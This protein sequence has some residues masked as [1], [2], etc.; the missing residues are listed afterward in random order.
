MLS[1]KS[2]ARKIVSPCL[3]VRD[4]QISASI[5][6]NSSGVRPCGMHIAR[7]EHDEQRIASLRVARSVVRP[8]SGVGA[9]CSGTN[10]RELTG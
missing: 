6:C 8:C 9:T 1:N 10:V 5:L 3:I 4:G 7:I 2:F